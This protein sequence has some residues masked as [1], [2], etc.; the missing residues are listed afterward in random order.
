MRLCTK[1]QW[2]RALA[3]TI[4]GRVTSTPEAEVDAG[5]SPQGYRAGSRRRG[6]TSVEPSIGSRRDHSRCFVA[7]FGELAMTNLTNKSLLLAAAALATGCVNWH[8]W[9]AEEMRSGMVTDWY[10]HQTVYTFDKD[11]ASPSR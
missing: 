6:S 8:P 4:I 5:L 10:N 2:S 7:H 3:P 9:G 11:T 1:S